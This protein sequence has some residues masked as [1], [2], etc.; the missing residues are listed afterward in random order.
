LSAL[1][2]DL[3]NRGLLDEVLVLC[4]GEF[5]R[6]PRINA[7]AGRDH[8]G[9]CSSALLAGGGIRGGRVLGASDK[10]AAYPIDRPVDPVDIHATMHH[11]L[12]FRPEQVIYDPLDR[13]HA[14]ST[15]QVIHE[16]L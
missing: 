8:W 4:L 12:G 14:I 2:T 5:G 6:T 3:E 13:P 11:C 7:N 15:G 1:I 9:H 16:L 10:Q